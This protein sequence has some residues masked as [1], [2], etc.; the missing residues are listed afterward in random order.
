MGLQEATVKLIGYRKG[1]DKYNITFHILRRQKAA[2]K[3][4]F[5]L[6]NDLRVSVPPLNYTSLLQDERKK[7]CFH[8]LER[9]F[10]AN[11]RVSENTVLST[12]NTVN[13]HCK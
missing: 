13:I 10:Y 4:E 1:G 5:Q 2:P 9:R 8:K 12:R 7:T 11:L 6:H 3:V